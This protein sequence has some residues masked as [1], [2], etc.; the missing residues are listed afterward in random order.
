MF[1]LFCLCC[2]LSWPI[3]FVHSAILV[4]G[5]LLLP[6][7]ARYCCGLFKL[8][9]HFVQNV[10]YSTIA[11]RSLVSDDCS[12]STRLA[13]PVALRAQGCITRGCCCGRAQVMLEF[14]SFFS[15][16]VVYRFQQQSQDT[17]LASVFCCNFLLKL[18]RRA[19][20]EKAV[21]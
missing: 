3:V 14:V 2:S 19:V 18:T 20:N 4:H 6:N 7:G 1:V 21:T 11:G 15:H 16:A 17:R 5:V 9:F 10:L 13:R 8:C 12:L